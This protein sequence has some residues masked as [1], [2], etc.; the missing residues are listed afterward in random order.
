MRFS[1]LG[2]YARTAP[3]MIRAHSS[4]GK[5]PTPVPNAGSARD[6]APSSSAARR[7]LSVVRRTSSAFVRRSCPITAPWTTQRAGSRPAPVATASPISMGPFPTASRSISSPPAR[8]IAPATPLPIQRWLLAAFAIASPSRAVMSPSTTSSSVKERLEP[9][10]QARRQR[11][12]P[13]QRQ[14]HPRHVR[15]ARVGVVAN[16]QQLAVAAEEHL[17]VSHEARQPHRMDLGASQPLRRRLGR[18]GRGILLLLA[19]ELDDLG[20]RHVPRRL[21]GQPHHQHRPDR[22]VGRIE[23]RDAALLRNLVEGL[24]VPAGG[25]HHRG[26]PPLQRAAHVVLDGLRGGEVDHRLRLLEPHQLMAG[27]FERRPEHRSDLPAS[28]VEDEPHAAAALSVGLIRSTAARKRSSLGPIPAADS[29][30]GVSSRPAS[31]ASASASTA[32]ISAMIRSSERISVSVISDLPSLLMRFEVDSIESRI[33]PLRF[34]F[35]RSSSS[36]LRFPAAPSATCSA[37]IARHS[38]RFSSRVPT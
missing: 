1:A 12:E 23:Q 17:L 30:S 33:R 28:P 10:R 29:C 18:P 19:V 4:G 27:R 8:L 20:P 22:E 5:P 15:L 16:R 6:S 2:W 14:E 25:P 37:A 32:S 21:L 7:Q 36:G 31:S 34:S 9:D 26:N 35:A 24:R 38:S 3:T 13:V 11:P